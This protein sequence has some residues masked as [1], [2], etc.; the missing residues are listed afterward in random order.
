MHR[1]CL[2]ALE[3]W[4]GALRGRPL[5]NTYRPERVGLEIARNGRGNP[6]HGVRAILCPDKSRLG[7]LE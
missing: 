3:V 7:M 6:G 5:R 1:P 2:I 4:Q